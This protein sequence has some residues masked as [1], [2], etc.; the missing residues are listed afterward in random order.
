MSVSAASA[1][2]RIFAYDAGVAGSNPA[3]PTGTLPR[4]AIIL[5]GKRAGLRLK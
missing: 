1:F 3:P 4:K 5:L 2:A